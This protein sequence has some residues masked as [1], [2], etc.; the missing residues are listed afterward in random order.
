MNHENLLNVFIFHVQKK[1]F[2][3]QKT[4]KQ[5]NKKQPVLPRN[6]KYPNLVKTSSVRVKME[7]GNL[8]A[9]TMTF[10]NAA[11]TQYVA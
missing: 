6:L 11:N 2:T 4:N 7:T 8:P 10:R 3:E 1:V 9:R 5:R